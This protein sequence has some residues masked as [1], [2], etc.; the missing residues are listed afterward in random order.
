MTKMVE[1]ET[2]EA[3]QRPEQARRRGGD[4]WWAIPGA[5]IGAA[6]FYVAQR[7]LVDD[8]YIT[9]SY[10]RNVAEHLHWGMIPAA[11]SNTATS[12]LNVML[13]AIATWITAVMGTMRP[14]L[15]LGILI[16]V[17]SAAMAAWAAQIGRRINV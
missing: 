8:A 11:E 1:L 3:D 5:L 6:M 17:L 14:V 2:V 4:L 10:V 15:G 9:L 13:L 12:P 7:G 16:V